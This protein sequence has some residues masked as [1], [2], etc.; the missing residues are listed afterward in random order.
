ML[1]LVALG[2]ISYGLYEA[3]KARYARI[4]VAQ[5]LERHEITGGCGMKTYGIGAL[6][7]VSLMAL[8]LIGC[9]P[10]RENIVDTVEPMSTAP[11]G[12]KM[13][14]ESEESV[15]PPTATETA[16]ETAAQPNTRT[17]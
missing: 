3:I 4:D 13:A 5:R 15:P 1:A 10:A 12:V 14:P 9:E 11:E 6:A 8:M 2:V 17:Q 7:G 16:T